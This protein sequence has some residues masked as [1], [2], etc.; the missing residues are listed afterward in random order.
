VGTDRNA[1]I[2]T[3]FD[4]LSDLD[5]A[6]RAGDDPALLSSVR[7][8]LDDWERAAD[9][10]E[11]PV[12]IDDFSESFNGEFDDEAVT[13]IGGYRIIRKLGTG[14]MSEVYLAE[15]ADDLYDKR[16]AVKLVWTGG[17]STEVARRF[18]RERR[19]L[20]ALEH[21]NIARLLDGGRTDSGQPYVVM[22]YVDGRPITDYCR[23]QKLPLAER[24]K[25]FQTV[26]ETVQYAHQHLVIHRDLKPGNILVTRDGTVK[27]LDFG[28]AKLL[29]PGPDDGELAAEPSTILNFATP[30]Y[31]SPEHLRGKRVTTSSD[32]YSL[33][34]LLY[35]LLT[36]ARP[37]RF[38]S[39]TLPE[40]LRVLDEQEPLRPSQ[41]VSSILSRAGRQPDDPGGGHHEEPERLRKLLRG[42]L[43]NIILKALQKEPQRRY[44][45]PQQLSEDLARHL[46]GEPVIAREATLAY[47]MG[48]RIRRNKAL[49]AGLTFAVLA[50]VIGLVVTRQ[51]LQ[52]A[53]DRDLEQRR[54]LYAADM[55]QAGTD[56]A[57]GNLM[58][59]S[60]LLE[61]HRPPLDPQSTDLDGLWR[62]FE[63]FALWKMLHTEK[64]TL[65]HQAW[66]P[67]VVYTPDG[68]IILTGSRDGRIEMWDAKSGQSMGLFTTFSEGVYKLLISNDGKKLIAGGYYGRVGIWDFVNGRLIAE[69][70]SLESYQAYP[71]LSPD[72]KWVALKTDIHPIR[73]WDTDTGHLVAE[74]FLP[75]RLDV[76]KDGPVAY[77][78]DGRVLCL[79][80][81]DG[82][83]ELWDVAAEIVVSRLQKNSDDPRELMPYTPTGLLISP[84]GRRF[85]LPTRDFHIRA[86]D[87]ITGKLLHDFSGHENDVETPTLSSDG[88]WLATGSDDMTL[89]LWDTE[90]GALLSIVQ[91]ESQT[92][93]PVF[94]PDNENL[95]AVCMRAF[96]VKVWEVKKLLTSP[97]YFA[98]L[99]L[100]A[101]A[102]NG[103]TFLATDVEPK[104]TA[105]YDLSSGQPVFSYPDLSNIHADGSASFSPN[106]KL[107][108]FKRGNTQSVVEVSEIATGKMVSMLYLNSSPILASA[109]SPNGKILITAGQGRDIKIWDTTSLAERTTLQGHSDKVF[110]LS[111]SPDGSR[112]A[113]GGYDDT[114]KVWDIVNEKE[115]ITLRG[116]RA[117]IRDVSFSPDGKLLAS[118][119]WDFTIKLWNVADGRELRTL[120]GHANSVYAVSFSP[121]GTRLASGGD[122]RVVRIWDV[123][124]GKQLTALQG[125]TDKVWQVYF[126]PDGKTLLSSSS[127]EIRVWR[128]ATEQEVQSHK[129][130]IANQQ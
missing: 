72:G 76:V 102:P 81:R 71:A 17:Q 92:F 42:D 60:D 65:H 113:S 50:L 6:E 123:E 24:L 125:H 4:A 73:V 118:A 38:P 2:R 43:D 31:A 48:K 51:Q 32:V 25:L 84:D 39:R 29:E 52:A 85:Y 108:A 107:L 21:P 44:Q 93:S 46:N 112:L 56:W 96:R 117:W 12:F 23:E 5:P 95:A 74:Y 59:M 16:V 68:R 109:F 20:A 97:S 119:S 8:L 22:E 79:T 58:Q 120:T 3:L 116:H 9:F 124:T 57:E 7:K 115:L 61:R 91:N 86:W 19:I 37:H 34:V 80:R 33:G 100:V 40:V 110:C 88:K 18:D 104:H 11:S 128:A 14:G 1:E 129:S 41:S 55:R 127:N 111:F 98:K 94:S 75:A 26:C 27:L 103:K 69:L 78:P 87:I 130:R 99:G 83:F 13:E 105:M 122:D 66:V 62:G 35:E 90:S 63:W 77:T 106:G 89:R 82:H 70:P 28:I 114:V 64:F 54:E 36:G 53:R 126:T 49:T 10:L 121:D 15:R 67:T 101:I 47:R 45:S 30:E